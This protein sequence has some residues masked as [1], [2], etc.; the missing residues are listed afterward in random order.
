MENKE[1]FDAVEEQLD[2]KIKSLT[3]EGIQQANIDYLSKLVD[4]KK[5]ISKIGLMEEDESMRY[6]TSGTNGRMS[7]G[8][9]DNYAGGRSRDSRGRF[10]GNER[11]NYVAYDRRYRGHD[12]IDDMYDYY[13][14]YMNYRESGNYGSPEM[15]KALDYML[16]SVEEFMMMLKNDASSQEEVEKIRRTAR[17][18]ADM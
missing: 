11:D 16:K 5:D 7:Y 18:I 9:Y 14:E 2:K 13:G 8:N 1:M 15:S 10:M 12:Q 17:K 3:K 6:R 4:I